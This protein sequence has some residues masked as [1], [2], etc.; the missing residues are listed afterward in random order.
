VQ[1]I[2]NAVV[3]HGSQ[4]YTIRSSLSAM[5]ISLKYSSKQSYPQRQTEAEIGQLQG[6]SSL[7]SDT[8]IWQCPLSKRQ[9]GSLRQPGS[10]DKKKDL[11]PFWESNSLMRS[12]DA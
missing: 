8:K 2:V 12:F 1:G 7:L 10:S 9:N 6:W 5:T 4:L 3:R 11:R